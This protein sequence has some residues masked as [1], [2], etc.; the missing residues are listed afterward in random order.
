MRSR[1]PIV[2]LAQLHYSYFRR[3]E[4]VARAGYSIYIYRISRGQANDVRRE[5]GLPEAAGGRP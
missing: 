1:A 2:L 3:F 4:P 5:L